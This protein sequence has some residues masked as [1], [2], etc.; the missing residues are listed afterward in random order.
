MQ[1]GI[2]HLSMVP[3]RVA[4]DDHAQMVSQLLYG[5]HFKIK[6]ERKFF[7]KI[8]MAFDGFEGWVHNTQLQKIDKA[9]FDELCGNETILN[10]DFLTY[11]TTS[12][13]ALIPLV[14]GSRLDS[15]VFLG[16]ELEDLPPPPIWQKAHLVDTALMYLNAPFLSGGTTPFG[17][18]APGFTQMVYRLNGKTLYRDIDRQATQGE[19][20]SFIEES[21]PGDLAFF[22]DKEGVINHVGIILKDHHI[23]HAS[24]CVRIDR[25]DHTGIFNRQLRT[26]THNLRVIKKLA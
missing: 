20:L 5:D 9:A 26:Y 16:H 7:S 14:L 17:I 10:L 22:D 15:S 24:G 2:A 8:E 6:E 3:I 13:S 18:D 23:I 12:E 19:A 21:E 11:A 1:Y 4:A 25:I